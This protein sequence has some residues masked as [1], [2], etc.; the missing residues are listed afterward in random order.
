[1]DLVP[2]N[3]SL[4]E[5]EE[6]LKNQDANLAREYLKLRKLNSQDVKRF[7]IGYIKKNPNFFEKIKDKYDLKFLRECG[8]FFYDEK[9]KNFGGTHFKI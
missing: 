3:I 4:T 2:K 9:N 7:K 1:M 5:H 6:I 8:L